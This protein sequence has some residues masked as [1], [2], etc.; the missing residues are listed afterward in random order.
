MLFLGLDGGGTKTATLLV[1][2]TGQV[3]GSGSAGGSNYHSVGM[4]A[5]FASVRQAVEAALGDRQ[6]DA[7]CFSMAGGDLPHDFANLNAKLAE[8]DLANPFTVRND[9]LGALRAGSRSPYGVAVVCGTSYN[10]AAISRS[11]EEFRL[12]ALGPISGD[13]AGGRR[14]ATRALGAAFRSWDGRGEPTLLADLI[15]AK[16]DAPDF[17]TVASRWGQNQISDD[18]LKSLAPLV[19]DACEAGD[20]LARQFVYE[21]GL[22]LGISA[23]AALRQTDLQATDCDV[24][25]AGSIFYARGTLLMQTVTET[26]LGYAPNVQI[27]RLGVQ[28]VVGAVLLAADSVGASLPADFINGL[29]ESL[30]IPSMF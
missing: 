28:P 18:Q 29:P 20:A 23:N 14:L 12:P 26:I 9:V 6:P 19:F 11:G 8:L 21:Q 25:L 4:D 15:L 2:E 1:D 27:K 3:I 10:A 17:E 5:A 16:L 24:V 22:E 13:I 7:T 30:K